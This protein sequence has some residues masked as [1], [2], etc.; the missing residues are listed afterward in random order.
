MKRGL[1]YTNDNCRGCNKCIDAC[2]VLQ[3]NHSTI[4]ANGRSIIDVDADSCIHCGNCVDA[5]THKAREFMDD[6][7]AF[8][9]ALASGRKVSLLIA[10]AFIA[11][12]PKQYKQVLGYLKKRG[13]NHI[14]SVSFGADITTWAYLN[15]ITKHNFVGGISQ[16]C[17]AIVDYIEK[18]QPELVDK[19]VPV[20][21]PMMCSAIYAKK[22]MN[23]TDEFAF[24]SPCI[25]KKSEISRPEN[26]GY[27][28]YNVT[29][30]HLFEKLKG[31]DLTGFD[32]SDE[33]EYGL[34]SVYPMPG[35]LK[36]NV[37][38]FMGDNVMIRQMEGPK[39]IYKFLKKY[40]QRI[41]D[42]APLPFMVDALN[43]QSGC[44]FGT[45][46][47]RD[48]IDSED[49]IMAVHDQKIKAAKK[50][51]S[52]PWNTKQS[53]KARLKKLNRAFSKL[54]L[55]DFICS[56]SKDRFI[57]LPEPTASQIDK[58]FRSLNKFTD[59]ERSVNCGA[60][61]YEGGCHDM[62]KAIIHGI[63][64]PENCIYYIKSVVEKEKNEI[65][66]MAEQMRQQDVVTESY[67]TTFDGIGDINIA[68]NELNIGNHHT[69]DQLEQL[70]ID[71]DVLTKEAA[72]IAEAVAA[73]QEAIKGYDNIN[74]EVIDVS[75]QT[76]LLAINAGIEAAHAGIAGKGFA[77]IAQQ[78]KRL[79][80]QIEKTAGNGAQ[81]SENA[82]PAIAKLHKITVSVSERTAKIGEKVSSMAA[83]SHE[84][85]AQSQAV[86]ATA[87]LIKGQM[88]TVLEQLKK[89]DKIK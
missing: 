4:G 16:P 72:S 83:A 50:K 70:T 8:F 71:L 25:A 68:I 42:K 13:V 15:Y 7:D 9:Q 58:V 59:E 22:Y 27:I 69:S 38:Y 10:P 30:K 52:S 65:T 67:Q 78:V 87:E 77:V 36:N 37:E 40:S 79:A 57:A 75:E 60:C 12:Y 49:T 34:G 45:A 29:F 32:A 24:L 51:L 28:K 5:C 46:V 64:R 73:V 54:K 62:A 1:I 74:S 81:H 14:I 3:V 43:C 41:S 66:E 35:G 80:D 23:I 47:E 18:Y 20:H 55:E 19:L 86:E 56:Y 26:K 11:N 39:H 89:Y 61:G 63:N 53:Q 33:I 21:S 88:I 84:I 44:I 17:P 2:P 76:G 48:K 82:A 6:T 31:I 85:T